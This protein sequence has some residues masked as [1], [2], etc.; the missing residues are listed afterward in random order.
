MLAGAGI[1]LGLCL[2]LIGAFPP[3]TPLNVVLA[4]LDPRPQAQPDKPQPSQRGWATRAMQPLSRRLGDLGLPTPARRRDLL[5]LGRD[6]QEHLT[7]KSAFAV[8]GLLAPSVLGL[9]LLAADI[10]L[11]WPVPLGGG[12]VLATIGFLVPDLDAKAQARRRRAE[13]R[14]ALAVFLDLTVVTL[15]GGAGVEGALTTAASVGRGWTF[16]RIRGA[17][18]SSRMTRVPPW[19]ELGRLGTELDVSELVELASSI[20]LAGTEGA[21]VRATL[22]ARTESLRLHQLADAES[23]AS[24]ATERM[25]LPVM[26][27]FTGF[28][29]FIGYPALAAVLAG[30]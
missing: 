11:G 29:V 4:R 16:D 15:A 5:V 28:L 19:E 17:L 26:V 9:V 22:T 20:S 3:R 10:R 30:L 2:L 25:S 18:E 7:A 23:E 14:T 21:R 12:I 6:V 1:G 27:L 8:T 13:F 24:A